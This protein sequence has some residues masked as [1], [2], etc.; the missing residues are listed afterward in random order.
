M[1]IRQFIQQARE[2]EA[3]RRLYPGVEIRLTGIGVYMPVLTAEQWEQYHG[4]PAPMATSPD[5]GSAVCVGR[6][7]DRG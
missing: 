4:A 2:L 7:S 3:V 6:S 5:D 1:Q